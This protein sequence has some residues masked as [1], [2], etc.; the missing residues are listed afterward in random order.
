MKKL[1]LLTAI[2][3][4][5]AISAYPQGALYPFVKPQI[6]KDN[7]QPCAG[8]SLYA[9]AA[10][11]T[12]PLAT[13][14]DSAMTTPNTNPIILDSAGR[15]S[16]WLSAASY[17]FV[18]KLTTGVTVW[19]YDNVYD[20]GQILKADLAKT[21]AG[22][23]DEMIGYKASGTGA[24]ARTVHAEFADF[25]VNLKDYPV[26]GTGGVDS[27]AATIQAVGAAVGKTLYVPPGTYK[28]SANVTVPATVAI[29]ISQGEYF[30]RSTAHSMRVFIKYSVARERER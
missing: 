7:G 28:L 20:I 26:D 2:I 16:I 21:T 10:G 3:A 1:I 24:I 17:K 18:L 14:S 25:K 22:Y 27:S 23:G 4:L 6:M 30:S 19:T 5:F 15:A 8:C 11:T 12:T 29:S 9:Y 13:Y